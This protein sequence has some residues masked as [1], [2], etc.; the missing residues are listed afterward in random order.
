MAKGAARLA[1]ICT[2]H[3]KGS[4]RPN[5]QGS[6]DT[7]F[8]NR[9]AHRQS[10]SW[11]VHRRPKIHKSFLAD[12]SPSVFTNSLRQGRIGDPVACGSKVMT[13]SNDVFIGGKVS[14]APSNLFSNG[15]FDPPR[16]MS[17]SERE[18]LAANSANRNKYRNPDGSIPSDSNL[19]PEIGENEDP[20]ATQSDVKWDDCEDQPDTSV[21]AGQRVYESAKQR[22]REAEGGAWREGGNNQNIMQLYKDVGIP[23]NSDSVHWCAGFVGSVLKRSCSDYRRTL[24]AADYN[25]YGQ[26]LDKNNPSALQPGDVVVFSRS[27]GSGHVAI[28]DRYDPAT[29]K[30]FYIGGNQSNNV[31][32]GSR[33]YNPSQIQGIGRPR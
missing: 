33:T 5:N 16:P 12:G 18:G 7:F 11:P 15:K 22:L 27:G 8:N 19:N 30:I 20:P 3:R 6:P 10:D 23:Q 26:Q 32:L 21:P 28:V 29:N 25:N 14:V 9:P 4:P 17:N 2:G 24:R 13:G 1:D 31:T